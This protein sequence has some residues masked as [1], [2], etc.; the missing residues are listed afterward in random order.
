M[1]TKDFM[2][3]GKNKQEILE[4]KA[5]GARADHHSFMCSNG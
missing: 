3:N 2:S 4:R 1:V 5:R